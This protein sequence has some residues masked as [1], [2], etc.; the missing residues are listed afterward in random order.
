MRCQPTL[1]CYADQAL[2]EK[3]REVALHAFTYELGHAGL[4]GPTWD[5]LS[6]SFC[7]SMCLIT[8]EKEHYCLYVS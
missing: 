6:K 5:M 4:S 8:I 7:I 1:S 2:V 3:T